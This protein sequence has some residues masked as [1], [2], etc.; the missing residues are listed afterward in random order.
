MSHVGKSR[1][2]CSIPVCLLFK[3]ICAC[4]CI[5]MQLILNYNMHL[6][7]IANK[8]N[9]LPCS[10]NS[11]LFNISVGHVLQCSLFTL[12]SF[13]IYYF[14]YHGAVRVSQPQILSAVLQMQESLFSAGESVVQTIPAL[15]ELLYCIVLVSFKRGGTANKDGVAESSFHLMGM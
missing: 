10:R 5:K 13:K 11:F 6:C 8:F 12:I 7:F 14:S 3:Y 15:H 9:S 1:I 2:Q 4:K